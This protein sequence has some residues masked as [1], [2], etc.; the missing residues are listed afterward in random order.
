MAATQPAACYRAVA[1]LPS[2]VFHF[3]T[4]S[5]AS[6]YDLRYAGLRYFRSSLL[7]LRFPQAHFAQ[8]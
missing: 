2:S 7:R 5:Y 4:S 6:L 8:L 3:F 1:T